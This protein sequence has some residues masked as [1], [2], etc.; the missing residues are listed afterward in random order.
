MPRVL[1]AEAS[2]RVAAHLDV[3]ISDK[4]AKLLK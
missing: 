4:L 1:L 2:N 3:Q